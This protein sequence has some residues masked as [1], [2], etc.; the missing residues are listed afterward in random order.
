M[1][2]CSIYGFPVWEKHALCSVREFFFL[3][4]GAYLLR[5]IHVCTPNSFNY[6]FVKARP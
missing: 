2:G 3:L 6:D 1:S 4:C 5:T